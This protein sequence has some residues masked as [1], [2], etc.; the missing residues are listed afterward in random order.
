MRCPECTYLMSEG[1]CYHR[2]T[3]RDLVETWEDATMFE[4]A[5][6]SKQIELLLKH[7]REK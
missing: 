1:E 3:C 5:R 2:F 6:I 4:F 7:K